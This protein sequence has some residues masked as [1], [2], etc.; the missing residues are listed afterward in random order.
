MHMRV[1]ECTV[2]NVN[3]TEIEVSLFRSMAG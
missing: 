3:I 2:F 1:L